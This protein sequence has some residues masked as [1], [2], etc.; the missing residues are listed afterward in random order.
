[1]EVGALLLD[2][3][4]LQVQTDK[5]Y[6]ELHASGMR[7]DWPPA[8]QEMLTPPDW[9]LFPDARLCATCIAGCSDPLAGVQ[10]CK[11]HI[12]LASGIS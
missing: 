8:K 1:M 6:E 11:T 2:L 12:G 3:D 9:R 5:Q 4:A 7:T 10:Y